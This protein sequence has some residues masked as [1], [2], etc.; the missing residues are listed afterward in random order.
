VQEKKAA[1][2]MSASEGDPEK[3]ALGASSSGPSSFS[4]LHYLFLPILILS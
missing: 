2:E 4:F 1:L 3:K